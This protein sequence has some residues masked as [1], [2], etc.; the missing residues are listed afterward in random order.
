MALKYH[1]FVH[2]CKI[3]GKLMTKVSA[4]YILMDLLLSGGKIPFVKTPIYNS[5]NLQ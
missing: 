3:N 4:I 5:I 2:S 1:T